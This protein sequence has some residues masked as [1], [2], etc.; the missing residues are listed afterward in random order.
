M[1]C[2]NQ[3]SYLSTV[4]PKLQQAPELEG[5]S[6]RSPQGARIVLVRPQM[7]QPTPQNGPRCGSLAPALPNPLRP[8]NFRPVPS[9]SALPRFRA[10]ASARGRSYARPDSGSAA[11]A[12]RLRATQLRRTC[13]LGIALFITLS[14]LRRSAR[15]NRSSLI[16][17]SQFLPTASPPQPAT[18]NP[19]AVH[20]PTSLLQPFICLPRDISSTSLSPLLSLPFSRSISSPHNFLWPRPKAVLR[21]RLD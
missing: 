13:P 20:T 10:S 16:P 4:L 11:L 15:S 9:A 6:E 14:P 1:P 19:A 17:I 3:L 8:S 12:I 7:C 5:A 2:S 18:R 21:E